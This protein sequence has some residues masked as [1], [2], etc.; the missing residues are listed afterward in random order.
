MFLKATYSDGCTAYLSS[1]VSFLKPCIQ[2]SAQINGRRSINRNF[3]LIKSH[4]GAYSLCGGQNLNF[5]FIIPRRLEPEPVGKTFGTAGSS[6]TNAKC[7][8]D[9]Y[10]IL[11]PFTTRKT[12]KSEIRPMYSRGARPCQFFRA[13]VRRGLFVRHFPVQS[14]IFPDF[15]FIFDC[16]IVPC[17]GIL[18]KVTANRD[19]EVAL[20]NEHAEKG[21]HEPISIFVRQ[22]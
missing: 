1:W 2:F 10:F 19:A 22:T 3:P 18:K 13:P 14:G 15:I 7:F 12:L 6:P 17:D 4:F 5:V 8:E 20:I 21:S 9:H 16:E 11:F